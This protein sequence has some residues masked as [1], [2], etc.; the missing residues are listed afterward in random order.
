MIKDNTCYD[1]HWVLYVDDESLNKCIHTY[2]PTILSAIWISCW[3]TLSVVIFISHI[4]THPS[5]YFDAGLEWKECYF[6]V[7]RQ[8]VMLEEEEGTGAFLCFLNV[9]CFC[10]HHLSTTSL[11]Q[12]PFPISSLIQSV[13]PSVV[14]PNAFCCLRDNLCR[15]PGALTS[16]V[17][18]LLWVP[19]FY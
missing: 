18:F 11:S 9:A 16:E 14:E 8:P 5:I 19:K 15:L 1:G 3:N 4:Q 6:Y 2:L 10:E 13:V 17:T 7:V 12:P